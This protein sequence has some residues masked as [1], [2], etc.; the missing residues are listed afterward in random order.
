MAS[1]EPTDLRDFKQFG[2][3]CENFEDFVDICEN[4]EGDHDRDFNNFGDFVIVT[5]RSV[6][7]L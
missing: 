2:G 1:N 3:L 4:F 7:K 5:S 6:G